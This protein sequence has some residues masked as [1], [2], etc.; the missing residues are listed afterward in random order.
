[1]VV[2]LLGSFTSLGAMQQPK[3]VPEH[4]FDVQLAEA[5]TSENIKILRA[6][7]IEALDKRDSV[8]VK[9]VLAYIAYDEAYSIII[10]WVPDNDLP[11]ADKIQ[12]WLDF[13]HTFAPPVN[14]DDDFDEL[15][16][17]AVYET[18]SYSQEIF[19]PFTPSE[20]EDG[21]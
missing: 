21:L 14:E 2:A 4:E 1:M 7:L 12:T 19:A 9:K 15:G 3:Q 16:S 5:A 10:T 20:K 13:L 11:M 17:L 8:R 6:L 18:H